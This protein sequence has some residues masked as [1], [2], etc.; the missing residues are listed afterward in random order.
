M[1]Q[2]QLHEVLLPCLFQDITGSNDSLQD[3]E[4]SEPVPVG[5]LWRTEGMLGRWCLT[6]QGML[7]RTRVGGYTGRLEGGRHA[8]T[9]IWQFLGDTRLVLTLS[10]AYRSERKKSLFLSSGNC[11]GI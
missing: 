2:G 11:C 9:F 1:L 3:M 6:V 8:D 5:D 10:L 7:R 4:E